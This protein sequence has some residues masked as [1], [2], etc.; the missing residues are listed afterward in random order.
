[1]GQNCTKI[2][3]DL[4]WFQHNGTDQE[5][6]EFIR[7]NGL[8]TCY[9]D[10]QVP[11]LKVF[12]AREFNS[13]VTYILNNHPRI[14]S[15]CDNSRKLD[16]FEEA[17][18][19][20]GFEHKFTQIL[21]KREP[22]LISI[23]DEYPGEN[24]LH[25]LGKRKDEDN[26]LLVLSAHP[27]L[28]TKVDIRHKSCLRIACKYKLKRL[29]LAILELNINWKNLV[30][31]EWSSSILS[32]SINAWD[33]VTLNLMTKAVRFNPDS[34]I[35]LISL[36]K[37]RDQERTFLHY[38]V[39]NNLVASIGYIESQPNLLSNVVRDKLHNF[40]KDYDEEH[41]FSHLWQKIRE[42]QERERQESERQER[43][44]Q[45]R[46]RQAKERQES[47]RQFREMQ[48]IVQDRWM[49]GDEYLGQMLHISPPQGLVPRHS[50]E[51]KKPHLVYLSTDCG[52]CLEPLVEGKAVSFPCGHLLHQSCFEALPSDKKHCI[53]HC[54]ENPATLVDR[55]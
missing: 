46:E 6:C 16:I 36:E 53:Y 26:A 20:Y 12:L 29:A 18:V 51:Q 10:Y 13:T 3:Y 42:I 8:D 25:R 41:C 39:I 22:T 40:P 38:L 30:I 4:T 47:D 19:T 49:L 2:F 27:V 23:V 50:S 45:E 35:R 7:T 1:M 54:N 32:A 21:L 48:F 15:A 11:V 34:R 55:C 24:I 28:A 43:E 31:E 17:C 5:A 33:E 37:T 9:F 14:F 52:I 44:R